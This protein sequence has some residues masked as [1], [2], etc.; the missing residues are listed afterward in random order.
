MATEVL[1]QVV[2]GG[3]R[4]LNPVESEKLERLEGRHVM[5]TVKQPRNLVFHRKYFALL[6]TARSMIDAEYT[7]EQFRALCTVGAGHCDFVEGDKGLVAIPRSIS[8]ASMDQTEFERL[9]SDT[10][11]FIC[12]KWVLDEAQLSAMLE[13]M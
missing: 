3:L 1:V 2:P 6:G 13:F 11:T 8:F 7:E 9:Y 4:A 10:L 5:A 12:Q